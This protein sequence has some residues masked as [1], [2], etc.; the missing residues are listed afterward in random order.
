MKLIK[1][2][3][4]MIIAVGGG[5]AHVVSAETAVGGDAA[6]KESII[7]NKDEA[8]ARVKEL[9]FLLDGSKVTK[10]EAI[11]VGWKVSFASAEK[12]TAQE[13]IYQGQVNVKKDDGALA[14][15]YVDKKWDKRQAQQVFDIKNEKVSKAEA[16]TIVEEFMDEQLWLTSLERTI[17][18]NPETEYETR[19]EDQSLHKIKIS[20]TLNGIRY[21]FYQ[22]LFTG[23]V[24]RVTGKLEGYYASWSEVK[25]PSQVKPVPLEQVRNY[26]FDQV[27]PELFYS[28]VME[29]NLTP[30]LVWS[31]ESL[32]DRSIDAITGTWIGEYKPKPERREPLGK[33]IGK[34]VL[35]NTSL[36]QEQYLLVTKPAIDEKTA[37]NNALHYL[38]QKLPGYDTQ[39]SMESSYLVFN[40]G[41]YSNYYNFRYVRIADGILISYEYVD[42]MVDAVTGKLLSFSPYLNKRTIPVSAKPAISQE[43]AKRLLLSMYDIDLRYE[44]GGKDGIRLVYRIAIKPDTPLF[45]TGQ[46]P[47]LDAYQ[48][49]WWN[50]LAEPVTKPIPPASDWLNDIISSPKRIMYKAAVVLNG[51]LLNLQDEP[52]LQNGSTLMP[53]RELLQSL[54]ATFTWDAKSRKV[55]ASADSNNIVLTIGSKTAIINGKAYPLSVPAQLTNGRTYVPLRF[56]AEALGGKVGWNAPSRLVLIDTVTDGTTPPALPE[57]EL[58]KHRLQ[59][60]LNWEVK[61]WQ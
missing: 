41:N 48:V 12:N 60:Q 7:A 10:V 17:D 30:P 46:P 42:M 5:G 59:A 51:K 22:P 8:I 55:T 52:I 34:L 28:A 2:L 21:D 57:A 32:R 27:K 14:W 29:Q 4:V 54:G 25:A 20:K 23:Y 6:N 26:V 61:H 45:Y 53:F 37:R 36:T 58:K 19:F 43:R 38:Q 18:S 47:Y 44:D 13:L 39:L 50:Y 56:A 40:K 33:P 9:G 16:T 49:K 15:F 3:M 24:D 31:L 11:G 1:L 35:K